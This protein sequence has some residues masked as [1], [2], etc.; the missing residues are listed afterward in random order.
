MELP[1]LPSVT[2]PLAL[3]SENVLD[4]DIVGTKEL[5][6]YIESSGIGMEL[7]GSNVIQMAQ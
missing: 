5:R 1:R 7:N 4:D 6:L 2:D 3:V